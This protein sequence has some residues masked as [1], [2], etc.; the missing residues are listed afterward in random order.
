MTN[1][2]FSAWLAILN[3]ERIAG[4]CPICHKV[5]GSMFFSE[6]KNQKTFDRYRGPVPSTYL[7]T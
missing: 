4:M 1:H 2:G 3:G 5:K 7:E 6:E